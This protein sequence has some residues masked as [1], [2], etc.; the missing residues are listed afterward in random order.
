MYL[1]SK[2]LVANTSLA[3]V[4]SFDV[5]STVDGDDILF[6]CSTGEGLLW[7]SQIENESLCVAG[8]KKIS[9]QGGAALAIHPTKNRLA[10]VGHDLN[11]IE[12]FR[13]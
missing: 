5:T 11:F 9:D 10:A 8:S 1:D 3:Q 6:F 13:D 2:N 4:F 12:A 7:F